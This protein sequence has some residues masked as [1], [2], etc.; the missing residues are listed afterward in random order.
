[1]T[2][3]AHLPGTPRNR[4]EARLQT[5]VGE[6]ISEVAAADRTEHAKFLRALGAGARFFDRS[7]IKPPAG[8]P[9]FCT[10]NVG[11]AIQ[12]G[13]PAGWAVAAGFWA[14]NSGHTWLV[15]PAGL[16]VDPTERGDGL[17]DEL[18]DRG[19]PT[20]RRVTTP[21]YGVGI[22]LEIARRFLR[23]VDADSQH[24]V[25]SAWDFPYFKAAA[26]AVR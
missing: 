23:P 5:N 25:G 18:D 16:A 14:E 8:K 6:R 11:R 15:D 21:R 3:S 19:V 1:M 17:E 12:A 24:E 20:G 13:L 10:Y 7:S 26:A 22:P 9:R 2:T 4:Q